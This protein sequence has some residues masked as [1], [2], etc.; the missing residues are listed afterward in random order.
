MNELFI[1]PVEF[2]KVSY[3]RVSEN[4][5][6][7]TGNV[8]ET[9]YSQFPF[10]AN[11]PV[12]VNLTDKDEARGYA[13]G[14][15]KI[16][17]GEGMVVPIVIQARELF[18]FDVCIV[19]NQIMPLT[20]TT[21]NLY[22]Q[23][24]GAFLR[25]VRPDAGDPTN[26]LFNTSFSQMITPTYISD[27]YKTAEVYDPK[28]IVETIGTREKKLEK[29]LN[30][31][32]RIA[33]NSKDLSTSSTD[34]MGKKA[35]SMA[36][37]MAIGSL[38]AEL[39]ADQVH[40][41]NTHLK[42]TSALT[43]MAMA[44][45]PVAG[46][47]FGHAAGI[48]LS[49]ALSDS[50]LEDKVLNSMQKQALIGGQVKAD[51]LFNESIDKM[52][53]GS[54]SGQ[55]IALCFRKWAVDQGFTV[56]HWIIPGFEKAAGIGNSIA[57]GITDA[58]T[59]KA[60]EGVIK[61]K[62]P[63]VPGTNK[64][65]SILDKIS[66]TITPKMK[67]SFFDT[68]TKNASIAEGFK[69]NGTQDVIIKLASVN[70]TEPNF[71]ETVRK[72][73][74]RD[75]HYIYKHGAYDY[76]GI[77][78]NS[79]VDDP[80]EIKLDADTVKKFEPISTPATYELVKTASEV[81]H[82]YYTSNTERRYA[83]LGDNN[84]YVELGPEIQLKASEHIGFGTKDPEHNKVAHVSKNVIV[85]LGGQWSDPLEITRVYNDNGKEHIEA[86]DGM[87]KISYRRMK[88]IDHAYLENGI[89]YL[90]ADA[91]FTKIGDRLDLHKT[92]FANPLLT[93]E[94][95]CL[96]KYSYRLTGKDFTEYLKN[97]AAEAPLE[98]TAW[99]VLQCGGTKDDIEKISSLKPNESYCIPHQM[100]APVPFEKVAQ[101]MRNSYDEQV[102][103]IR[104]VSKDFI[105]EASAITDTPTV[106]AVLS[107]NFVHRDN[108]M[109]FAKALPEFNEV[110]NTL[111]DMLLKTRLGVQLVD[112]NVLR[113]VMLGVVDI[114][115][116]LS[117]VANLAT[118]K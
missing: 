101:L 28:N 85:E 82:G 3:K 31:I 42:T 5:A 88:G 84:D 103:A 56:S 102:R 74:E 30:A 50:L 10:F 97:N 34:A 15:I 93:N 46:A 87:N 23:S 45:H 112:E 118:K 75:I 68:L 22:V 107:L 116:V 81:V 92:A 69:R 91:T 77:F 94:V 18:P 62:K 106:D 51:L 65:A 86:W 8:M 6:E 70:T 96:D 71:T 57:E 64:T 47:T 66:S 24:R 32:Q 58:V 16:E 44:A 60:I 98:K 100:S 79:R 99:Y 19:R 59:S 95:K 67:T 29:E 73:L 54:R 9:F 33:P 114:I 90:P 115:D 109:E 35:S 7:W 4:P 40:K 21:L 12:S 41:V 39:L 76:R 2:E 11:S 108:I 25:V 20:N 117:G 89:T 48:V 53:Q 105:K 63:V 36:E 113:R 110:A 43:G 111:A 37:D 38:K 49:N 52:K 1:Q 55:Y 78:G 80:V 26:A 83:V 27:Q 104:N 13:I 14:S 72:T 61:L 17:E